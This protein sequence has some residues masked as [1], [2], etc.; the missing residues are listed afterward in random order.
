MSLR[1]AVKTSCVAPADKERIAAAVGPAMK[2]DVAS[3][4]AAALP[5]RNQRPVVS[6]HAR[7]PS[8]F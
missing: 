8:G 4:A 1:Q 7:N 6:K 3:P 2:G 5:M